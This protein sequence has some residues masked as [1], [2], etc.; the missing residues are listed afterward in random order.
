MFV[1]CYTNVNVAEVVFSLIVKEKLKNAVHLKY[2]FKLFHL[3]Y[4][5]TPISYLTFRVMTFYWRLKAGVERFIWNLPP[6]DQIQPVRT[7]L[8][9]IPS[10]RENPGEYFSLGHSIFIVKWDTSDTIPEYIF[11]ILPNNNCY[12]YLLCI[13]KVNLTLKVHDNWQFNYGLPV[14]TNIRFWFVLYFLFNIKWLVNLCMRDFHLRGAILYI[15]Y[16]MVIGIFRNLKNDF[17][18]V[19]F[20]RIFQAWRSKPI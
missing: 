3:T 16:S 13:G 2:S 19:Y 15:S 4:H 8:L 20:W 9:P 12:L 1:T 10:K 11:L 17:V 7:F 18:W 5:W 14:R 6:P